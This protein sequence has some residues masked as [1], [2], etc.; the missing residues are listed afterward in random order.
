MIAPQSKIIR[1]SSLL[2]NLFEPS[3]VS[4]DFQNAYK[5]QQILAILVQNCGFCFLRPF[6]PAIATTVAVQSVKSMKAVFYQHPAN[7]WTYKIQSDQKVS[8]HLKTTVEKHTN[9]F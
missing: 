1:P 6:Q 8:V 7:Y 3:G 5:G 9:T 2:F 4:T